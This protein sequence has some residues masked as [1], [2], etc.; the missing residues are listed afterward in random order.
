M[1]P[2]RWRLGTRPGRSSR[3]RRPW[4]IAL[5]L[6]AAL[7]VA[8][9]GGDDTSES[10]EPP[11]AES[12]TLEEPAPA[13][14]AEPID[15]SDPKDDGKQNTGGTSPDDGEPKNGKDKGGGGG[16]GKQD[17]SEVDSEKNDVPPDPGS[18]LEAFEKFCEENPR[19]CS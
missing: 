5:A 9:C 8:G 1:R 6:A 19:A 4:P 7:L 10:G 18:P 15:P 3:L 17:P 14:P 11:A 16:G 2:Y 12:Q 13:E